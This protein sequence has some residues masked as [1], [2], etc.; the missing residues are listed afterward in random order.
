MGNLVGMLER[1]YSEGER[2]VEGSSGCHSLLTRGP[3]EEADW[4]LLQPGSLAGRCERRRCDGEEVW[5]AS[6]C[7]CVGPEEAAAHCGAQAGLVWS[8]LGEG[9]CVCGEGYLADSAGSCHQLGSRGPCSQDQVW[10][11]NDTEGRAHCAK[12]DTEDRVQSANND[13]QV[14]L[15]ELLSSKSNREN[16]NTAQSQGCYVDEAGRCR[17]ILK[18]G[19]I[20]L[21][22]QLDFPTWLAGCTPSNSLCSPGEV[23]PCQGEEGEEGVLWSDGNCYQLATTG[24]CPPGHWL[25]LDQDTGRHPGYSAQCQQ[26]DC[27]EEEVL[28]SPSCSCFP[29]QTNTTLRLKSDLLTPCQDGERLVVSPYGD[30][31]CLNVQEEQVEEQEEEPGKLR[32]AELLSS[33]SCFIDENGRCRKPLDIRK[34]LGRGA[35]QDLLTWLDQFPSPSRECQDGEEEEVTGIAEKRVRM[36]ESECH[37]EGKILF[38]DGNCYN[39]L[40]R[41]PCFEQS[42][43][44]VMALQTDGSLAAE[45]RPRK[46]ISNDTIWDPESCQCYAT[47]DVGPC[48]PGERLYQDIFGGG[49]CGC[50]EGHEVWAETG[51]CHQVGRRGPCAERQTFTYSPVS[52]LTSC[53]DSDTS[54]RVFDIIPSSND[55]RNMNKVT[56]ETW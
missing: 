12:N 13:N 34:I 19:A 35:L 16:G 20:A 2:E 23:E 45:C 37:R 4:V 44:V 11:L 49:V 50:R 28:W 5:L 31:I 18:I 56:K 47:A 25:V 33:K 15:F 21:R 42:M 51:E 14:R 39:L 36:T 53:S 6:Q 32:I 3:C 55:I 8:P 26:R 43:W 9:L 7:D 46:C 29:L 30:G 54:T 22:F 38:E 52:H 10:L 48:A 40:E 24:P 1:G 41:G 27:A 17:K